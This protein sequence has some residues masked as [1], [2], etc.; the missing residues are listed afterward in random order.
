MSKARDRKPAAPPADPRVLVAQD[1]LAMLDAKKIVAR[2][3]TYVADFGQ[4]K[5]LLKPHEAVE[6]RDLVRQFKKPC[7]V[8]ALGAL[9]LAEVDRFDECKIQRGGMSL[10]QFADRGYE[11]KVFSPNTLAVIE[12]AF[13]EWG[14]EH[15]DDVKPKTDPE[16]AMRRICENIIANGGEF[17]L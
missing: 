11:S 4:A 5:E 16:L 9:F 6:V 12:H 8:C 2:R 3:M 14:H 7:H 1:V 13:E 10:G 17:V 15:G